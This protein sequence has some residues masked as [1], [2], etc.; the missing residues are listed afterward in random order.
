MIAV[1]HAVKCAY[2]F[3]ARKLFEESLRK[4]MSYGLVFLWLLLV[5]SSHCD[6]YCHRLILHAPALAYRK[7]SK[8]MMKNV[9]K[10]YTTDVWRKSSMAQL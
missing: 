7:S 3:D 6:K 1:L 10:I 5:D 9:F 8:L 2:I 4:F